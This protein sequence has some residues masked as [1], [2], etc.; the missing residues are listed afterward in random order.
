MCEYI[1]RGENV[2]GM[3]RKRGRPPEQV[4]IGGHSETRTQSEEEQIPVHQSLVL[5]EEPRQLPLPPVR[6]FEHDVIMQEGN[7]A[8]NFPRAQLDVQQQV[9]NQQQQNFQDRSPY[10]PLRL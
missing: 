4:P 7:D 8:G 5:L 3:F 1:A 9:D 10:N 6:E 2:Q